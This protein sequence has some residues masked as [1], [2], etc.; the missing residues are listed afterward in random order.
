MAR[1]S[2]PAVNGA[3]KSKL[4]GTD[5]RSVTDRLA[6][7]PIIERAREIVEG[8]D[9]GVTLRQLYYRL[10]AE[11]WFPNSTTSYKRLSDRTT[12]AREAGDF[13]EL[14]DQARRIHR[15]T[16]WGDPYEVLQAAAEQYRRDR[17]EGQDV[18][19]YLGVEKA[20]MVAQL[21]SWF[22]DLGL[23]VVPL[24]GYA[25]HT[26]KRD[27]S[28]DV[29]AM[30][31]PA[32]LLYAG[33]FDPSG[34]DI[35]RD[36]VAKTDCW[37][38]VVRVALSPEQITAHDLPE[39]MGKATDSR[40]RG[41]LARHGRLVQVELD[42]LPP[43]VLRGLFADALAEFWDVSA[44]ERSRAQERADRDVLDRLIGGTP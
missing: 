25:S 23:P 17:T 10:V 22:G 4:A 2:R 29:A 39:A 41:F 19:V 28:D 43:E 12:R 27:V 42:A 15:P 9:T 37:S 31:R 21:S 1:K 36:F 33:D 11:Q 26:F 20:G 34:E 18:S 13:P 35:D 8:Y 24:G 6:W 3:A 38:K 44:F 14:I 40:A 30:R 5:L 7:P 16:S 32:V